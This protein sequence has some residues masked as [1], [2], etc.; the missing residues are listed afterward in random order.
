MTSV[1]HPAAGRNNHPH[2]QPF[3]LDPA[4]TRGGRVVYSRTRWSS[5]ACNLVAALAGIGTERQER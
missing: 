5:S 4:L 2:H 3:H 1:L